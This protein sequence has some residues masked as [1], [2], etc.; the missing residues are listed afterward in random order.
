MSSS[1]FDVVRITTGM[2]FRL[3]SSL[4]SASTSRPSFT[5]RFRSS[6]IK[7]GLT[8]SLNLPCFR[9]QASASSPLFATVNL[10]RTLL[11]F[12][13]SCVNR[14]SPAL[15][16]TSKISISCDCSKFILGPLLWKRFVSH[17]GYR[18]YERRSAARRRLHGNRSAVPLGDLLADSQANARA[19]VFGLRVQPLENYP[20]ALRMFLGNAD[21]V[22]P[23]RNLPQVAVSRRGNMDFRRPIPA[24]LHRV[25]QQILKELAELH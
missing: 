23:D 12:S 17:R 22:V 18:E 25:R 10:L 6:R 9:R 11:S 3:A 1:A 5:G 13:T 2:R 7:S 14:T 19:W 8:Q 24:K 21:A 4:I 16:S 20:N 15:S